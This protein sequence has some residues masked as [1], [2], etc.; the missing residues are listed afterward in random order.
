MTRATRILVYGVTGSGKTVLARR[1]AERTGLPWHLVDNLTHEPGWIEVLQ[2]EQR[3]RIGQICAGEEWILD[4][5]Y[6][7]WIDLPLARANLVVALD[8]RRWISFGRLVR[9]TFR[10][11]RDGKPICNGNTET[12][13]RAFASRDSMLV[14]HWRSFARKRAR[15]RQWETQSAGP[16]VLRMSS[17]RQT[18]A[19]LESL[20]PPGPG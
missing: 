5:A 13:R 20:G 6:G 14:W 10:R 12:W 1:I 18:Q 11:A 3:R 4:S 15:I 9:R 2:D 16:M 17:P 7:R 19:W 8:Y